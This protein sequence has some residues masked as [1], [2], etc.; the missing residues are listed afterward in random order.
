MRRLVEVSKIGHTT[1]GEI[2]LTCNSNTHQDGDLNRLIWNVSEIISK[3]SK[4]SG[5]DALESRDIIMTGAPSGVA[6][7]V[8]DDKLE[9][10]LASSL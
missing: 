5:M 6:P 4:L 3:L 7:T 10:A 1:K 8:A 2:T 9:K